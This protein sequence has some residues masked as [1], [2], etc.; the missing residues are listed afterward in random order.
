MTGIKPTGTPH[1]GN[2]LGMIRPALELQEGH[3]AFYFI[4]SYHALTTLRDR[5]ALRRHTLSTAATFL[6]LG[7]DPTR[8]T[9]YRQQDV[10]EVTELAWIL[11]CITSMGTLR[12]AHAYKAACDEG[13]E[14]NAGLFTYPVLMAADILALDAEVVP[15]GNDQNQ[16]IEITRALA[17]RF[18]H[19]F[20]ETFQLPQAM[21]RNEKVLLGADGRKMGKSNGNTID[22]FL[23]A[24]RLRK[25]LMSIAT[26][27]T[28]QADP[29]DPDTCTVFSL[30]Q[31][32]A[33]PDR[34]ADLRRRYLAGGIGYGHAKQELFEVLN[35]QLCEPRERY[36]ELMEQPEVIL[37]VLEDGAAKARDVA[38]KVTDQVRDAVGL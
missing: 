14:I 16:H 2:Y 31:A 33:S 3:D 5:E 20:G 27:S 38:R 32:V 12:R 6:A 17:Q 8:S 28:P 30:F 22:I 35:E 15:V 24:K 4:A 18:N 7:L 23:P 10:P 13:R 26:D 11:N 34:T 36:A 9:L 1:L 21:V 29:K 37:G 25:T 19:H